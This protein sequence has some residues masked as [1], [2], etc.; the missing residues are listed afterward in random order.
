MSLFDSLK[1]QFKSLGEKTWERVRE[2]SAYAQ[3]MDRYENLTPVGQKF[4]KFIGVV[5]VLM[6]VLFIP[7]SNISNSSDTISLFEEERN[8]IRELFKTYRDSSST[9][10][11]SIPPPPESLIGMINSVIQRAE[12]LP[13]QVLGLN[14]GAIE[15][16]LIAKNLVSNVM[17][18][19]LAKL[20]LKQIVDIGSSLV[21]LSES[22]KMK[23]LAIIAN[24]TDTRYYDVTYQLYSLNI[25]T[26]EPEPPPEPERKITKPKN[27]DEGSDE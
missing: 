21:G 17:T 27:N 9:Q 13:E 10:N 22:V 4:T 1:D 2:S 25:P 18:V 19:K 26:P 5:F 20:N 11:L 3:G 7:L 16:R 15:G 6:F 24:A 12:L 23:D 8:L 14:E